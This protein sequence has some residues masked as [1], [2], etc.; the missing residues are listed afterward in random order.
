[1]NLDSA[2]Q[3]SVVGAA[4]VGDYLFHV[5]KLPEK[6]EIVA[7]KK[8]ESELKLG[9]CG[10]NIASGLASLGMVHPIL[11]YPVGD[12]A[13]FLLKAWE[14][15]GIGCSL[16]KC[17]G[18]SGLSWMFM[19]EGGS[20]M[21]FAWEGVAGAA[22]WK[23]GQSLSPMVIVSPV[24]NAFTEGC[25]NQAIDEKRTILV[26]GIASSSLFSYLGSIQFLSINAFEFLLLQKAL[27]CDERGVFIKYPSLVCIVTEGRKGS[28]ILGKD[29]N[30]P[31]AAVEPIGILDY[32][33]AGDAYV[34][35]FVSAYVKGFD[36]EVC[37]YLGSSNASFVLENMGGQDFLPSWE[38]VVTRLRE[39]Y[40]RI[41]QRIH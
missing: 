23:Q 11:H 25:L 5:D 4:A 7:V 18:R 12:D 32:T 34:S 33:G 10:P 21:C 19:Q 35:G 27:V 13:P 16:T 36:L 2:I 28:R 37:G 26:T 3:V 29:I 14:A 1:M 38:A 30:I 24:L 15:K 20:T 6:G 9:G 41:A 17:D 8:F 39:Q 31:I 40:P 22:Q